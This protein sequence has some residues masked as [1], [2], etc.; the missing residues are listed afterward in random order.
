MVCI[1]V[2][3]LYRFFIYREVLVKSYIWVVSTTVNFPFCS[4]IPFSDG[5]DSPLLSKKYNHL[6]NVFFMVASC[7]NCECILHCYEYGNWNYHDSCQKEGLREN[8]YGS[9]I[10]SLVV[11]WHENRLGQRFHNSK[12][13]LGLACICLWHY[14]GGIRTQ[15][16]SGD[17]LDNANVCS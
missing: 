3:G 14:F 10:N 9:G 16:D 13:W 15:G 11:Y 5:A 8:L 17:V 12:Q 1:T 7:T 2:G 4:S 6:K